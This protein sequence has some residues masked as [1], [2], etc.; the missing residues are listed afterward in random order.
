MHVKECDIMKTR[1]RTFFSGY[2]DATFWRLHRL[3]NR[4]TTRARD[5]PTSSTAVQSIFK[6]HVWVC[7]LQGFCYVSVRL[8]EIVWREHNATGTISHDAQ[9]RV[10]LQLSRSSTTYVV[11]RTNDL[12]IVLKIFQCVIVHVMCHILQFQNTVKLKNKI[13]RQHCRMLFL[14]IHDTHLNH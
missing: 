4:C 6:S 8:L 14:Y 13:S 11:S 3:R 5:G 10:Y 1:A 12:V 9:M 2:P 7:C